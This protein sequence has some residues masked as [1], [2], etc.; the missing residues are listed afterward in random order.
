MIKNLNFPLKTYLQTTLMVDPMAISTEDNLS[1]AVTV[2]AI[3]IMLLIGK[4]IFSG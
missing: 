4:H 1:P 3:P 2:E